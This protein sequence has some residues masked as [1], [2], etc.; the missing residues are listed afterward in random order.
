M[1][2]AKNRASPWFLGHVEMLGN[3]EKGPFW[4]ILGH[5]SG[6]LGPKK[7]KKGGILGYLGGKRKGDNEDNPLR[8]IETPIARR[9]G[10]PGAI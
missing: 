9:G 3:E 7:G 8:G 5:P 2:L 4:T 6:V 1:V 10:A